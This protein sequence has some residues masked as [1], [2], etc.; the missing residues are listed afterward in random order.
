M[1]I[2]K[3]LFIK[4]AL[5]VFIAVPAY[6]QDIK[7][8]LDAPELVWNAGTAVR[9]QTD[10]TL[11]GAD[12]VQLRAATGATL[13]TTVSGPARMEF[14]VRVSSESGRDLF[15][16]SAGGVVQVRLSGEVGWQT[17]VLDIPAGTQRVDFN[18]I[19][20]ATTARGADTVWLDSVRIAPAEPLSVKAAVDAE[21]EGAVSVTGSLP[22]TPLR[23][24][25][26]ASTGESVLVLR[27]TGSA[28]ALMRI[29]I[30]ASG[31]GL[32]SAAVNAP[33]AA[34][35]SAAG[36]LK[37]I[38]ATALI[39]QRYTEVQ[40]VQ[41]GTGVSAF[42]IQIPAGQTALVDTLR[43]TPWASSTVA[44]AADFS[45]TWSTSGAVVPMVSSRS[46]SDGVDHLILVDTGAEASLSLTGPAYVEWAA[47]NSP[48]LI[49]GTTT[50]TPQFV[51]S[52]TGGWNRYFAV[53]PQGAHSVRWVNGVS[54]SLPVDL[55]GCID[56]VSVKPLT[57][58]DTGAAAD[59]PDL[60]WT[61]SGNSRFAAWLGLPYLPGSD[62]DAVL[63]N[64]A[65]GASGDWIQA[66]GT[67][68]GTI[69]FSWRGAV[70]LLLNGSNA[71]SSPLISGAVEW[72]RTLADVPP[73][74]WTARWLI[75][76]GGQS[77]PG[78]DSVKFRPGGGLAAALE[79]PL[80]IR[81]IVC[82]GLQ[83]EE[84]AG[85]G[86]A[87]GRQLLM[88]GA[89]SFSCSLL[90]SGRLRVHYWLSSGSSVTAPSGAGQI[91]GT[92]SWQYS[93]LNA[94]GTPAVPI[95]LT[96]Q[97]TDRSAL[98]V[99]DRLEWLDEQAHF[100]TAAALDTPGTVWTSTTSGGGQGWLGQETPAPATGQTLQNV[101]ED[102]MTVYSLPGA[103]TASLQGTLSGEGWL[104]W[105]ERLPS[106]AQLA[107][108]AGEKLIASSTLASGSNWRR[109]FAELPGGSGPHV[110]TFK[111]TNART[112]PVL[113]SGLNMVRIDPWLPVDG[114]AVGIPA[115][116]SLRC[117]PFREMTTGP[118]N[119]E[120]I[121]DPVLKAAL[122]QGPAVLEA[123][124][125][126]PV[127]IMCYDQ[128]VE[129]QLNGAVVSSQTGSYPN[130]QR[131]VITGPGPQRL[132]WTSSSDLALEA[133]RFSVQRNATVTLGEALDQPEWNWS[134]NGAPWSQ[135]G[136]ANSHAGG[137]AV[138]IGGAAGQTAVIET[139]H[140]GAGVL[141]F[142]LKDSSSDTVVDFPGSTS[143]NEVFVDGWRIRSHLIETAGAGKLKWTIPGPGTGNPAI[144]LDDVRFY[145]F[146]GGSLAQ[147]L[148]TPG[149]TWSVNP[150][151]SWRAAR[152]ANPQT[153]DG[154]VVIVP[155]AINSRTLSTTVNLPC[156]LEYDLTTPVAGT[157]ADLS[158]TSANRD[159]RLPFGSGSRRRHY[160]PGTGSSPLQFRA[161]GADTPPSLLDA[162]Y[163]G[164]PVS[165]SEALDSPGLDWRT[166]ESLRNGGVKTPEAANGDDAVVIPSQM[167][168]TITGPGV[169]LFRWR[170]YPDP[171]SSR[172]LPG[173]LLID[174]VEVQSLYFSEEWRQGFVAIPPGV[175]SVGF[176]AIPSGLTMV[177]DFRYTGY[178]AAPVAALDSPGLNYFGDGVSS[179]GW[180]EVASPGS[181]GGSHLETVPRAPGAVSYLNLSLSNRGHVYFRYRLTPGGAPAASFKVYVNQRPVWEGTPAQAWQ[182]AVVL[183]A[184]SGSS[185]V[186]WEWTGGD[187]SATVALDAVSFVPLEPVTV[188]E[189]LDTT[190]I[191]WTIPNC[192]GCG[193]VRSPLA[194]E[195][196][197]FMLIDSA[198]P[199]ISATRRGAALV[200]FRWFR[201]AW[202]FSAIQFGI[203]PGVVIQ[204][205]VGYGWEEV[206]AG[207]PAEST[208]VSFW[209][210]GNALPSHW[211]LVDD[212][213]ITPVTVPA[214]VGD[215][216]D[217][218]GAT[219]VTPPTGQ[220]IPMAAA[221]GGHALL[222]Q[223]DVT[224][225]MQGS[226][227][228][229]LASTAP[230]DQAPE[231][232]AV[233]GIATQNRGNA[234]SVPSGIPG[235]DFHLYRYQFTSNSAFATVSIK[236]PSLSGG[237]ALLDAITF[238]RAAQLTLG[239]ALSSG[240][241]SW[242]TGGTAPSQWTPT[243][244]P[245]EESSTGYGA[246]L[247]SGASVGTAWL[248]ATVDGPFS[249]ELGGPAVP[250][251][252][253]EINGVDIGNP[254]SESFYVL[255]TGRHTV[256]LKNAVTTS[257]TLH[258][259]VIRQ[260]ITAPWAN[261][262]GLS[263]SGHYE[264]SQHHTTVEVQG[265]GRLECTLAG[266]GAIRSEDGVLTG[267]FPPGRQTLSA[268]HQGLP[269]VLEV[270][271][272]GPYRISFTGSIIPYRI[273]WQNAPTPLTEACGLNA[274]ALFWPG[275]AFQPIAGG[276]IRSR[277]PSGL[278]GVLM[279]EGNAAELVTWWQQSDLSSFYPHTITSPVSL[280]A[281]T[282]AAPGEAGD[283]PVAT[284]QPPGWAPRKT[285]QIPSA[286]SL[287]WLFQGNTSIGAIR[288]H[289]HPALKPAGALE[290]P[291]GVNV[292]SSTG[293]T[294][295]AYNDV[296]EG[297]ALAI[298]PGSEG[299]LLSTTGPGIL[300]FSKSEWLA[301]P[302]DSTVT[303]EA[304]RITVDQS[305]HISHGISSRVH[306]LLGSGAH[307]IRLHVPLQFR[308]VP[309]IDAMS[310]LPLSFDPLV[311]LR[312]SSPLVVTGATPPDQWS[313]VSSAGTE[314]LHL[315]ASHTLLAASGGP[316]T[317]QVRSSAATVITY[318]FAVSTS[319]PAVSQQLA[320]GTG[321]TWLHEAGTLSFRAPGSL[322]SGVHIYE[323][324]VTEAAG[325]ENLPIASV[326]DTA[327][328][329]ITYPRQ[330]GFQAHGLPAL[331][332]SGNSAGF[333]AP[334]IAERYLEASVT[335]P[336]VLRFAWRVTG[337]AES[338]IAFRLNALAPV[339]YN[340]DTWKLHEYPVPA[341]THT[342]RWSV[343]AVNGC[344]ELDS[345][346]WYPLKNFTAW[347][348]GTP[349]ASLPTLTA[350]L[351]ND[352]DA[353]GI[354]GLLE[355][356][357][358]LNPALSDR[359]EFPAGMTAPETARGLPA[360]R[361]ITVA[362]VRYFA[363]EFPRPV[364]SGLTW[365]LQTSDRTSNWQ[366]TTTLEVLRPLGPDWELCRIV[367]PEPVSAGP[368]RIGR[369]SVNQP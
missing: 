258:K 349:L 281:I 350:R 42:D 342:L 86:Q 37:R 4:T 23:A 332:F 103:A 181:Q 124:F 333:F 214:V 199:G 46:S 187:A 5:C 63:Y 232:S 177:D 287:S 13:W 314:P 8:A 244:L 53:V 48:A 318:P 39:N 76:A 310:Y 128:A 359:R 282:A 115:D 108:F 284:A 81:N 51:N 235:L 315:P 265:P 249:L 184:D 221:V 303:P 6:T 311:A 66:S 34:G 240:G 271:D 208:G 279:T 368:R 230:P 272:A 116:W 191:N 204:S 172:F 304:L 338:V 291:S 97:S 163:I 52:L 189:A 161:N 10:V 44:A 147:A 139:T 70:S 165:F 365:K 30:S 308:S 33:T 178:A 323:L 355:Y 173:Q 100:K 159:V 275:S 168:A 212:V 87:G 197:D 78:L 55:Q 364:G 64:L 290:L 16:A 248:E 57:P 348:T 179:G 182:D 105:W 167:S 71:A 220:V 148:N 252:K 224:V 26:S 264:D 336:G 301:P 120:L 49:I 68:I 145:S 73:G 226:G 160:I 1:E 306:V 260:N 183:M 114:N 263:V 266:S 180:G 194:M 217:L 166:P 295:Y 129:L 22:V 110:I 195:G 324:N 270:P 329:G 246:V 149:R 40:F 343:A 188:A 341:G 62:T 325:A 19:K 257:L 14:K 352:S 154:E 41:P 31:P 59:A 18:Y 36:T 331:S 25:A 335:G 362:G 113:N 95:T 247:N 340:A 12:A 327:P 142:Y 146:T 200:R 131:R 96:M 69:E 106:G 319:S 102:A 202:S 138:V 201:P 17:A 162:F 21:F 354:P 35:V 93:D 312:S 29:Q 207:I 309:R 58:V 77:A 24:P 278:T 11:D 237:P 60:N 353:D 219:F 155:P 269:L 300:S 84:T 130:Y 56:A 357:F 209:F 250:Q 45:G 261:N 255:M 98:L 74:D 79:N 125:T 126:G 67:G 366:D 90:R 317:F 109:A 229:E 61:L 216:L 322:A 267:D 305:P 294:P 296:V 111:L 136:A 346:A 361:I 241:A 360:F 293:V 218:T 205:T 206:S 225:R 176:S 211:A 262:P 119:D 50:V 337:P 28:A 356:A 268:Q 193:G 320:A 141:S 186:T 91:T 20:D 358:G 85:W 328:T 157:T 83:A 3:S 227:V 152:V 127:E 196:G 242:T 171:L 236:L 143:N 239:Q 297:D 137:S 80:E 38:G 164:T 169:A 134:H 82:R 321:R 192:T 276:G 367:A 234:G 363:C 326:L 298:Q 158:F 256:R 150:A 118:S 307:T 104:S 351:Q 215:A 277:M 289:P 203:S 302:A 117:S 65:A 345:I 280:T 253:V 213:S 299:L 170:S 369:L 89:P 72:T 344:G 27:N 101:D 133:G 144:T 292:V 151:G 273:S 112:T 339:T 54:S 233:S 222:T 132:R 238:R 198:R 99:V 9:A 135:A 251:L 7:E 15:E 153:G 283:P 122:L 231:F 107:V 243:V 330:S 121:S 94:A 92:G 190:G 185:L 32:F 156:W 140:P 175:H 210:D 245:L 259:A 334:G 313:F 274:A 88:K 316:A 75:A 123:S 223:N 174:G 2:A 228:L 47:R 254:G 288:R 285:V 43:W 286:T 347:A